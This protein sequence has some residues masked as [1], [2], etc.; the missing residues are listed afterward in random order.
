MS[1]FKIQTAQ[2]VTLEQNLAGIGHRIGAFLLDLLFLFLFYWLL[3]KA[4][5]KSGIVDNFQTWAFVSILMLPYFLYYPVL[6]YWNNGQTVGK[7]IL[8]L[9]VVKIDNS[10]PSIGDFLIRWIIRL[11]EI[12]TV[13]VA[14]IFVLINERKQ[15]LGD[16]A[17]GTTVVAEKQKVRLTHSIFEEIDKEYQATFPQVISLTDSDAQLIKTVYR[18]AKQRHNKKVLKELS[19]KIEQLLEMQRPKGMSYVK[20]ISTILKDFNYYANLQ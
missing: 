1:E 17:A 8:K 20:F 2:N 11:F 12:N 10:H 5:E 19:E 9:R 4:L 7:M 13:P 3:I 6:Q 15:R 16:M 14:I 18:E